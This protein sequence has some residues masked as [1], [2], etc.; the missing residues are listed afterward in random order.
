M[1]FKGINSSGNKIW[2]VADCEKEALE[3]SLKRRF[4]KSIKNCK[5]IKGNKDFGNFYTYFK[6]KGNDMSEVDT[7]K[8]IGCVIYNK[9]SKGVW[10]VN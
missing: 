6:N 9:F 8:G 5:L 4:V 3:I 2:I 1:L 10:K 7:K